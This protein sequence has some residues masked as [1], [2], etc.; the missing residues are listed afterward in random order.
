[1]RAIVTLS[2]VKTDSF[3]WRRHT[4]DFKLRELASSLLKWDYC[5]LHCLKRSENL[6]R[7]TFNLKEDEQKLSNCVNS[8]DVSLE[9]LL[10]VSSP[11]N[12]NPSGRVFP[13]FS[14]T[15]SW[16]QR[17][18]KRPKELSTSSKLFFE[19]FSSHHV[20]RPQFCNFCGHV[21]TNYKFIFLPPAFQ[22]FF[23]YD[24]H[25]VGYCE[26]MNLGW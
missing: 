19:T 9:E 7:D 6:E 8:H 23:R 4:K 13:D 25:N 14:G 17:R 12:S 11:K 10:P 20:N 24:G 16:S 15:K 5:Q 3:S 1:M 18:C 22:K 26:E 21:I 2:T